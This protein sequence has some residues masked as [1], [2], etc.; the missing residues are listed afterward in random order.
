MTQFY[1]EIVVFGVHHEYLNA[2][3]PSLSPTE[4][5]VNNSSFGQFSFYADIHEGSVERGVKRQ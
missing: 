2:D 3:R 5:H 1:F 4:M